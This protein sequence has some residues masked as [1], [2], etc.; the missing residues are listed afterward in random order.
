M[1]SKWMAVSL[2]LALSGAL[3]GCSEP[4]IAPLAVEQQSSAEQPR[5][6]APLAQ[7]LSLALY[8]AE[9]ARSPEEARQIAQRAFLAE[10]ERLLQRKFSDQDLQLQAQTQWTATGRI[11]IQL[12]AQVSDRQITAQAQRQSVFT[13]R[14]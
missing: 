4:V 1:K 13:P 5:L 7:A 3:L 14:S 9:Q 2:F 8:E 11:Q 10:L 12:Q 6:V